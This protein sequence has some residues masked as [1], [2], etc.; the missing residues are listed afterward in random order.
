MSTTNKMPKSNQVLL[1]SF[2]VCI[3]LYVIYKPS[4]P[5]PQPPPQLPPPPPQL[6]PPRKGYMGSDGLPVMW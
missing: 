6:P 3:I 1:I 5:I 2:A 4:I